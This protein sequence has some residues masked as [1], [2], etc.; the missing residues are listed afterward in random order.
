MRSAVTAA[1]VLGALALAAPSAQAVVQPGAMTYT[2]GAQCTSNFVFTDGSS[3]YL[4]QAAHCS[5]TGAA[6]DT[7]GCEAEV[8]PLNTPVEIDGASQPGT[9]AYN[10]WNTMQ[11][12]GESDG[13]TC[14]YNDFAL[15]RLHPDDAAAADP[16]VPVFGGPTGLG[17]A[18]AG[19]TVCSY[20]N[21]SLRGGV[22]TLSPKTGTVL[23]RAGGG[24]TYTLYTASPG[25]P[26]DSGSGFLTSSGRAFGV[27]STVAVA[28]LPLSNGVADLGKALAYARASGFGVDLVPGRNPFTPRLLGLL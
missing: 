15:V 19:E 13:D 18:S 21:S 23:E 5:S 4:G 9:L 12:N 7:N 17:E 25:I 2:G 10:S 1:V 26:G 6:T 22:G 16:T 24:W 27:L 8:L 14:E 20:Q 3:T 11:A 28:P